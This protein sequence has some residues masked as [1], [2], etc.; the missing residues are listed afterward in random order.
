M[1]QLCNNPAGVVTATDVLIYASVL[2]GLCIA[3]D[4]LVMYVWWLVPSIAAFVVLMTATIGLI[5]SLVLASLRHYIAETLQKQRGGSQTHFERTVLVAYSFP[6]S[7]AFTTALIAADPMYFL[8]GAFVTISNFIGMV[9]SFKI[10]HNA[11]HSE[12]LTAHPK[13]VADV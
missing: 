6:L 11:R 1:S 5:A 9:W 7:I 12:A 3:V 2:A 8:V 4:F 13:T 10:A